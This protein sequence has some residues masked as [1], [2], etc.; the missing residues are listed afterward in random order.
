MHTHWSILLFN[1][2]IV[3]IFVYDIWIIEYLFKLWPI[4]LYKNRVSFFEVIKSA[5]VYEEIENKK[6]MSRN[7]K[8][9]A[10]QALILKNL[11]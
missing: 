11:F 9:N 5:L 8:K 4:E 1:Y 3:K 2:W 6:S 7:W 10:D